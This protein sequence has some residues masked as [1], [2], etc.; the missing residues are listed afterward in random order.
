VKKAH[1][2]GIVPTVGFA[3]HALSDDVL[4][5]PFSRRIDCLPEQAFL[6]CFRFQ[7]AMMRASHRIFQLPRIYS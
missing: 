2:N 5:T 6:G 3:A 1:G 4:F 7:I